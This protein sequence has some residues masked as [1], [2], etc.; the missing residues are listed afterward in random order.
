MR[1]EKIMCYSLSFLSD[2]FKFKNRNVITIFHK[3]KDA[4]NILKQLE[5]EAIPVATYEFPERDEREIFISLKYPAPNESEYIFNRFF[6]SPKCA[7]FLYNA[8]KGIFVVD[9]TNY[10]SN[11]IKSSAFDQL[12]S[13]VNEESNPE[14]KIILL[15]N[16][17][18]KNAVD[19]R[20]KN[21]ISEELKLNISFLRYVVRCKF[22][23]EIDRYL[24]D[25]FLR[26]NQ[27]LRKLS[28]SQAHAC[29]DA[30]KCNPENYKEIVDMTIASSKSERKI[31]F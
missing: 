11:S 14:L 4:F 6:D 27:E 25:R 18:V 16:Q 9:C 30:I 29:L 23:E 13:Y 7:A 20:F 3:E 31:G 5:D 17:A 19:G 24:A 15:F 2:I 1:G 21:S 26:K 12:V 8:F 22:G 10:D 28:P